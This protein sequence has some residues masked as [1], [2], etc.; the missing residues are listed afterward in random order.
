MAT[1]KN[2]NTATPDVPT[3]ALTPDYEQLPDWRA[4]AASLAAQMENHAYCGQHPIA[5]PAPECA[6]CKDRA[7]YWAY[8][9]AAEEDR[10]VRT[11]GKISMSEYDPQRWDMANRDVDEREASRLVLKRGQTRRTREQFVIACCEEGWLANPGFP[12]QKPCQTI[13]DLGAARYW[14]V[15]TGVHITW[16]VVLVQRQWRTTSHYCDAHLPDE[17]RELYRSVG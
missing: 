14:E 4:I 15:H 11:P 16:K 17:F 12:Q 1:P 13:F 10:Q 5:R 6:F 7:V 9:R 3:T 2:P 8:R